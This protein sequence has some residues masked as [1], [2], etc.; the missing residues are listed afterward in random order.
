[1]YSEC[2]HTTYNYKDLKAL[3]KNQT[4]KK[5]YYNAYAQGRRNK[6]L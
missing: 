3:I 2:N 1:M 6:M 4:K 5:K